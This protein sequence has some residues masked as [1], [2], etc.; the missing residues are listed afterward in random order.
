MVKPTSKRL[1]ARTASRRTERG[2]TL[3]VVV[4]ALTMLTGIG[5]YTVHSTTLIAR[6]SGNERQA[7]QTEYL[8]QLGTL[9]TL[10]QFSTAPAVYVP[11]AL[12]GA[13]DCRMNQGLTTTSITPPSC[14]ELSNDQM[15]PPG[16]ALF[17]TDSFSNPGAYLPDVTG[18]FLS[19][20]TDVAPTLG[21]IAGMDAVSK[22]AF[23][24]YQA[25]ITT[26]SQLQPATATPNACVEGVMQVAGQHMTRAHVIVGPIG[27][28]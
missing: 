22:G 9:A 19:E 12:R 25:K 1:P 8:A 21:P 15:T 18:H 23:R 11:Y 17:E 28:N 13:D 4:L 7:M 26:I 3:F 6:A 5:L 27:G 10:S 16:G 14:F 24:L 20:T 2:A